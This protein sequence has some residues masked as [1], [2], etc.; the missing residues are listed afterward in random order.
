[1][2]GHCATTRHQLHLR[3]RP[4]KTAQKISQ[5]EQLWKT[6]YLCLTLGDTSASTRQSNSQ[7]TYTRAQQSSNKLLHSSNN[8]NIHTA[9][10]YIQLLV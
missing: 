3:T 10:L 5:D 6:A 2:R 9:Y 8:I 4:V 1:M 7:F